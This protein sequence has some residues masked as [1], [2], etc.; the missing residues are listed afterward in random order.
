MKIHQNL[1][2]QDDMNHEIVDIVD[3]LQV[4]AQIETKKS[5]PSGTPFDWSVKGR[6][7]SSDFT[8][9]MVYAGSAGGTVAANLAPE[10]SL[11]A[12]DEVSAG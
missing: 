2:K 12:L 4:F 3:K 11:G 10:G 9:A 8:A 7:T 6:R 1:G 5:G